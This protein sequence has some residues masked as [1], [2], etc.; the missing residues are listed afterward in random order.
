M[1]QRKLKDLPA[2][3]PHITY[4]CLSFPSIGHRSNIGS[5]CCPTVLVDPG[6]GND[7]KQQLK[8]Q[9]REYCKLDTLALVCL[10]TF[11]ATGGARQ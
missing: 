6:S 3:A 4:S 9:L 1:S 2:Q 8:A 11:L 10:A 7:H 5:D